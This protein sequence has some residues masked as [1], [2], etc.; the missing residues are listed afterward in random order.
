MIRRIL[1][2]CAAVTAGA[3]EPRSRGSQ[4]YPVPPGAVYS[5]PYP[6]SPCAPADYRRA[7]APAR[8]ISIRW[9]TTTMRKLDRAVASAVLRAIRASR[10]PGPVTA[11]A[12]DPRYGRPMGAPPVY[13]DR[14]APTGP[15]LSPD[16]PRY[17]RPMGAPPV[18]SD[19]GA[20]TGP[21][22]VAR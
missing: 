21:D 8:R 2:I 15:V 16:D 17:G 9:T 4:S 10:L 6:T 19:R 1:T 22:P 11:L 12:D 20:P 13:S 14:G 7:P 3:A 5:S 18:Y